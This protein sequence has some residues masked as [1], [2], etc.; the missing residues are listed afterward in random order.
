MPDVYGVTPDD[1]AAELPGL[2]PGGFG[3]GTKPTAA[4]VTSLITT[5]DTIVGLR[6]LDATGTA[7]QS[8]DKA[9]VLAERYIIEWVKGQVLRIVYTGADPVALSAAVDPYVKLAVSILESI[10][11]MAEQA[12]GTGEAA[13]RVLVSGT[14]TVPVVSRDMVIDDVDLDAGSGRRSRF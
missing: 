9:S 7:G 13:P 4:Q 2:F 11:I 14:A 5:A 8:T 6:I 1:V 3:A 10:D 12:V